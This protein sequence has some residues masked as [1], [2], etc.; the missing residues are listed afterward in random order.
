MALI[1]QV[2]LLNSVNRIVNAPS[3]ESA[4]QN[5]TA[6]LMD[7]AYLHNKY[8]APIGYDSWRYLR[9]L[10]DW[11]AGNWGREDD[12]IWEVRGGRCHFVYSKFMCWVTL[13]RR[14]RH[15]RP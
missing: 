10:I 14:S 2:V 1:L 3:V 11:M 9:D 4:P 12:G 13:G 7:A 15:V 8:S 5:T 6:E